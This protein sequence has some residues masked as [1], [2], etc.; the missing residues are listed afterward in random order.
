MYSLNW[1][2]IQQ[3][4]LEKLCYYLPEIILKWKTNK[5]FKVADFNFKCQKNG[6]LSFFFKENLVD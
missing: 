4:K 6:R 2:I 3:L 5:T 1:S